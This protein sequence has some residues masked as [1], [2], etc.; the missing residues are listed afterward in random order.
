MVC[1]FGFGWGKL[2]WLLFFTIPFYY[3]VVKVVEDD[4]N[5]KATAGAGGTDKTF[6]IIGIVTLCLVALVLVLGALSLN[7]F[8]WGEA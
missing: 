2:A 3:W 8:L 1:A 4:L 5:N 7:T 6:K